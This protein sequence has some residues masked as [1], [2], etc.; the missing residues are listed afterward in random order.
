MC[1]RFSFTAVRNEVE[2]RFGI[3]IDQEGYTP[4]YNCAPTQKLAVISNASPEKLSYYRWGLIPSWAKDYS[5]GN[6]LINAR[7]ETITVKPSFKNSFKRK[8]CLVL[9][10]GFYEWK[11]VEKEKIPYRILKEDESLFAMAGLWDTWK[12]AEGRETNSFTIITTSAN[13]MMKDLHHRMPVILHPEEEKLWIEE[14]DER[15]H[16]EL[17]KP[18]PTELMKAYKVSKLVNSPVN[19]IAEVTKVAGL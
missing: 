5:I 19:D 14:F 9:S 10:D 11:R 4:R 12:D 7:A 1:G 18:Y 15:K 6:K 13:E 17:L 8:R 2:N 16:L 3:F